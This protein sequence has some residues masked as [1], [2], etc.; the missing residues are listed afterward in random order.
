MTF[1][2]LELPEECGRDVI[3]EAFTGDVPN[4]YY[5]CAIPANMSEYFGFDGVSA[6]EI[7]KQVSSIL[8]Q[9]FVLEGEGDELGLAVLGVGFSWA[10]ALAQL[11]LEGIFDSP[12]IPCCV[13]ANRLSDVTRTPMLKELGQVIHWGFIDKYAGC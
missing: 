8:K 1:G 5:S 3:I 13:P 4:F 6:S 11:Y 10:C 12:D 2:F 7:E 9:P